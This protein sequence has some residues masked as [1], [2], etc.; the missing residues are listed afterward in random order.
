MA[1]IRLK[2]ALGDTWRYVVILS[3]V[4]NPEDLIY[5]D[6]GEPLPVSTARKIAQAI[7]RR[8]PRGQTDGFAWQH[9]M[10]VPV[11]SLAPV[12]TFVSLPSAQ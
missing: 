3:P 2:D 6:K 8:E 4:N 7:G 11:A 1:L 12:S 9:D 5:V 10:P